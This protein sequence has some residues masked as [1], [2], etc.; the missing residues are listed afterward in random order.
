MQLLQSLATF[1]TREGERPYLST[2]CRVHL[3]EWYQKPL[4]DQ[5]RLYMT[6][7]HVGILGGVL[8]LGC[9]GLPNSQCGQTGHL[10]QFAL[11][12]AMVILL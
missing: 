11:I 5:Q 8:F 3:G 2:L 12:C 10:F 7:G 1:W 4:P 9:D 6:L